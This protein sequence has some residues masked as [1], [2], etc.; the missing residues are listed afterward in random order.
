MKA[1]IILSGCG[2]YDGAEIHESVLTMLYLAKAGYEYKIFAP[3]TMQTH[4]INHMSGQIE[5]EERNVLIESARIARGAISPLNDY[6]PDD[7]DALAIPGGFGG[8]KNLSDLAFKGKEYAILPEFEEA[9]KNTVTAGKPILALCIIPAVI[10]KLFPKTSLTIGNETGT[11]EVVESSGASHISV[12]NASDVVYDES[13]KLITVPCYM[14]DTGIAE[15]A[16]G[17]EKGV[18]KL[19]TIL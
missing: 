18:K 8:A 3:D 19:T 6:N 5:T 11:A 13:A 12:E 9:V 10:S 1:A 2:V 16:E 14:F 15:V 7:F 4:V 17:I